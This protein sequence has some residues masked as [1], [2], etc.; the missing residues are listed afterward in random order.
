MNEII[1]T[2][3]IYKSTDSLLTTIINNLSMIIKYLYNYDKIDFYIL[4]SIKNKTVQ[5]I[6]EFLINNKNIEFSTWCLYALIYFYKNDSLEF[7]KSLEKINEKE[8]NQKNNGVFYTPSD[9]TEYIINNSLSLYSYNSLFHNKID[10]RLEDIINLKIFDPTSGTGAFILKALDIKLSLYEKSSIKHE[11]NKIILILKSLYG[12]DINQMSIFILKIRCLFKLLKYN[13]PSKT[14]WNEMHYNY[15]NVD[16]LT[17]FKSIINKF[18]IIVG[19]PPYIESNTIKNKKFCKYG[20]IYAD[21]IENSLS[22]FNNRG[23]LGYIIPLSYISTPRFE[24]LRHIIYSTTNI[25]Y[26][27]S[28]ADRPDSLF[29]GVHQKLNILIAKKIENINKNHMV[30]TSD[31]MHWYKKERNELFN[32]V[33]Y[34]QNNFLFNDCYPKIGNKIEISIFKKILKL[35]KKLPLNN[36]GATKL[37]L[38]MR[39]TYW[40]KSFLIECQYS[41]EYKKFLVNEEESDFINI[42][43]NSSIFWW[44]WIKISDCWHITLKDINYFRIPTNYNKK[45]VS[46]L[47]KTLSEQLEKTKVLVNTKQTLY[48]YKHKLCET[49]I[50]SIDEYLGKLYK[51]SKKEINYLSEYKKKYRFGLEH[52]K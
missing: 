24:N 8:N 7:Q 30:Y 45:E 52:E 51:L 13:I 36:Y 41:K 19:N 6:F 39:A 33:T 12:N 2:N 35:E 49:S 25:E 9:I 22:L 23:V 48:E 32:K 43:L 20:N 15:T 50:N 28:F 11:N 37:F 4:D 27:S 3:K 31:Y 10:L 42:I 47:S 44:F 40:I 5:E 29:C 38:N 34:I 14:I 17:D 21:I 1:N 18:D 46:K 16:F 26:I